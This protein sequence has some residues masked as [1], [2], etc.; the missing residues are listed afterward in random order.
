MKFNLTSGILYAN[1]SIPTN[2]AI[3]MNKSNNIVKKL[4]ASKV[5]AIAIRISLKVFQDLAN[6]NILKTL[7]VLKAETAVIDPPD[8]EISA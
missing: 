1:N 7:K 8:T 5:V 4:I 6:L 3:T 2:D